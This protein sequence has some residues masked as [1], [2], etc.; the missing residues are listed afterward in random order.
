MDAVKKLLFTHQDK[1]KYIIYG[2]I[3]ISGFNCLARPDYNFFLYIYIYYIW[4]FCS[5]N[6][7]K[8]INFFIRIQ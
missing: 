4:F 3:G 2:C 1:L 7:V 5:L 8:K 6:K